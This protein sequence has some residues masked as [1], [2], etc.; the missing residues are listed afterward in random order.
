MTVNTQSSTIVMQNT[1]I[2]ALWI[3]EKLGRISLCCL[4]SFV[5]QGHPVY[6]HTYGDIQD[7]PQ[8]ITICDANKI[9]GKEKIFKHKHT[10]SYAIFADI[11]RYE[12]LKHVN[13]IYVDCDMYCLKPLNI[14]E[15]GYL[16]GL[17]DDN[18][19]NNAVLALPSNSLLLNRLTDIINH[20]NFIPEWY[21]DKAKKRLKFKDIIGLSKHISEM[22]WGVTGPEALTY[23]ANDC[24]VNLLAQPIDIF[25]PIHYNRVS[26]LLTPDLSLNEVITNRTVAV[27]LY[28]EKLRQ[29]D[30]TTLN[31]DSILAKML[32]NDI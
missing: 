25:Y 22:N 13:G 21:S 7:L 14:P 16:F 29:V 24:Q 15:H 1:P 2:H 31:P 8:G 17:E 28:N 3:G 5:K 19:I 9:V 18:V 32:I 10:G 4:T 27:H 30:L 23:Y 20:K 12:L 26:Q 6:L 11:F